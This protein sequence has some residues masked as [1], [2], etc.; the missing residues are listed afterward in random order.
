LGGGSAATQEQI[1]NAVPL[2]IAYHLDVA[3][4]D[5]LRPHLLARAEI[6]KSE[7]IAPIASPPPRPHRHSKLPLREVQLGGFSFSRLA[8]R[9]IEWKRWSRLQR[10]AGAV[11][12]TG[13]VYV[14]EL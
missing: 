11:H 13:A 2:G 3:I 10:A 9:R 7:V 12:M 1:G 5:Y 8:V 6:E 14:Y 4:A